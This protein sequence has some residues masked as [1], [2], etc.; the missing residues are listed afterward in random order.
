MKTAVFTTGT[1]SSLLNRALELRF[2]AG[3]TGMSRVP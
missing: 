3:D 2:A 1:E